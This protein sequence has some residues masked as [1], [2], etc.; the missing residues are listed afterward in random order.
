[1]RKLMIVVLAKG[2]AA[3]LLLLPRLLAGG[4]EVCAFKVRCMRS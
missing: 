2:I 3:G 1:M 4:H